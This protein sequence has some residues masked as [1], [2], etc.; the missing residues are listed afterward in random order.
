VKLKL[1]DNLLASFR[2]GQ[3]SLRFWVQTHRVEL[4]LFVLLW[5]TFAYFYQSTQQNEAARFDQ[6]R[7]IVQEHRLAIDDYWW[8]SADVIR[9]TKNGRDYIYPNKAPGTTLLAVPIFW[10]TTHLLKPFT[11]VGL[12]EWVYWHMVAYF[13]IILTISLLSALAAV[14]IY[15]VLIRMS[16]D[17]GFSVFAVLAIWLGT[18]AFPFST[19]FFSHQLAAALLGIAFYLLFALRWDAEFSFQRSLAFLCIAGLLMGF[20]ITTEYPTALLVAILSVYGLWVIGIAGSRGE[21][22]KPH[23][24]EMFIEHLSELTPE[25]SFGSETDSS[26]AHK[27]AP[28]RDGTLFYE[29]RIPKGFFSQTPGWRTKGKLLAAFV[30][31]LVIGSGFLLWYNLAAFGKIFYVP[32]EA[33]SKADSSFPVYSRGFLGMRWPGFGQFMHALAAIT[34]KPPIGMLYI[35]VENWRLY[36]SSPVLWLAI[37]GVAIMLWRRKL[38][39]E[40]L[41]IAAMIF[42]YILFITSYGN[43]IYDWAGAA[44][45]GPRHIIPLLPFLSLPIYYGGRKLRFVFYPLLAISVFYMLLATAIE[46]R[47]PYPF[48]NPAR[49]SFLPDYLHGRLAQNTDALFDPEHRKLTVDSTAFNLA[50]LARVPRSYQL[51]P[52]MLWWFV[53][54]GALLLAATPES[55]PIQSDDD[56]VRSKGAS[57]DETAGSD[58]ETEEQE[59]Q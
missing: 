44:Y 40:G 45:I 52:L 16:G 37:P 43:S 4:V 38:R 20:S 31:G 15:R 30:L 33:Y 12:P 3:P 8:N 32:Y 57:A 39:P 17:S 48:E 10:V 25:S 28:G 19:L 6:T 54:G 14:A 18:M 35:G 21:S 1:G 59:D 23:S 5:G 22:G 41:V 34:I 24:G 46:P 55:Q 47:V 56:G 42:A 7:A 13:T 36:A 51:A 50:K 27:W 58:L 53:V 29:H 49:D 26:F 9:Y 11:A 2:Q